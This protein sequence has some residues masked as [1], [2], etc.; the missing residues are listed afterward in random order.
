VDWHLLRSNPAEAG[1]DLPRMKSQPIDT[2][3]TQEARRFLEQTANDRL[4]P[5]WMLMLATGL[6]RGEALGLRWEDV[7]LARGRVAILQTVVVAFNA[8][9]IS[10]P[11]TSAG[12]RVVRL[13]PAVCV[14]LR[15]HGVRRK[16]ERL[17]AGPTW[18]ELGLAFTTPFGGMLHPRN[19][20]RSF[21]Q[22]VARVGVRRICIHDLRHTAATLALRNGVH[23][24]LV[25][26]MLGHS[27]VSIT[28]NTYSHATEDMHQDAAERIGSALF[29]DAGDQ[30][31]SLGAI[32]S[33]PPSGGSLA[34]QE[35]G[36][37]SPPS[38]PPRS[39][40]W[41]S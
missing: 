18:T 2:W 39:R 22:T 34:N 23:P 5:L 3:S 16:E 33:R 30:D 17:H 20:L 38:I 9:L 27:N 40:D 1:L 8:P 11:K 19:V 36:Q 4:G 15:R 37:R 6:R 29:G 32:G 28:L 13:S 12:R 25:Q 35:G 7:D 24:K 10:E 31:L 14:A 21:D 26:E 41:E